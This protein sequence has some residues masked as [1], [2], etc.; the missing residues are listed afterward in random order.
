MALTATQIAQLDGSNEAHRKAGIGTLLGAIPNAESLGAMNKITASIGFADFVDGT[1]TVGTYTFTETIPAGA[2]FLVGSLSTVTEFLGDTSA[3]LSIGDGTDVDRYNTSTIDV[4]STIA[5][6]V[7][8]GAASGTLYHDAAKA[9]VI[10]ITTAADWT[11]VT[12]GALVVELYY[13]V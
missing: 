11:S 10:T 2:T 1:S 8:L 13:L 3:A 5:G 7:G 12:G 4:F 6:G 9:P